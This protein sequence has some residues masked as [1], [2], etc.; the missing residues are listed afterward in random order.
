MNE[1][2][3]ITDSTS[4]LSP[5]MLERY[6]IQVLPLGVLL[7]DKAFFHYPDERNMS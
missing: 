5:G 6:S 7:G 4:D 2:A 1:Y 3:I